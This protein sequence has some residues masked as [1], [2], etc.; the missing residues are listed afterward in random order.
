[1]EKT[2]GFAEEIVGF[3]S[4]SLAIFDREQEQEVKKERAPRGFEPLTF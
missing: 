4:S 1:M 2:D 3:P